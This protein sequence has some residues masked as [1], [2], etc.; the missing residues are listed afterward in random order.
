MF[1]I[2]LVHLALAGG[3]ATAVL[4][5]QLTP[6]D[7]NLVR[8]RYLDTVLSDHKVFA[9]HLEVTGHWQG[10]CQL[11][12]TPTLCKPHHVQDTEWRSKQEPDW[13]QVQIPSPSTTEQEWQEF[14][15]QA[16]RAA[17]T[18]LG[19]FFCSPSSSSKTNKRQCASSQG[20]R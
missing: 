4:N 9:G 7:L 14:H 2:P 11:T 8:C 15:S 10:A 1:R 12:S 5:S 18:A 13:L 6:P 17:V 3:K 19:Q 16:E 20:H